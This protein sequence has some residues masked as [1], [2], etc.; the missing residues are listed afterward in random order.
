MTDDEGI[1]FSLGEFELESHLNDTVSNLLD[2]LKAGCDLI[3]L[4]PETEPEFLCAGGAVRAFI[5]RLAAHPEVE[6]LRAKTIAL[7]E[8]SLTE[9]DPEEH[10]HSYTTVYAGPLFPSDGEEGDRKMIS[11]GV[12]YCTAVVL[13]DQ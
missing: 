5:D 1:V 6:E 3:K 12:C 8:L 7:H 4:L 10:V 2:G 11:V 13:E 9:A